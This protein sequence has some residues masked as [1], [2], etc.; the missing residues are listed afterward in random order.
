MYPVTETAVDVL[1]KRAAHYK[2]RALDERARFDELVTD[3][4]K[5]LAAARVLESKA[6]EFESAIQVLNGAF[7]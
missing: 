7:K 2:Q 3:M 5:S 1:S 4:H 6:A